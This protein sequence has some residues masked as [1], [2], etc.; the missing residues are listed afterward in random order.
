[1]FQ[2]V[3][4]KPNVV[5]PQTIYWPYVRMNKI[6]CFKNYTLEYKLCMKP[7]ERYRL[8][9]ISSLFQYIWFHI[10]ISIGILFPLS[11]QNC[12]I[13]IVYESFYTLKKTLIDTNVCTQIKH[14]W[15]RFIQ[16]SIVRSK[17]D[18]HVLIRYWYFTFRLPSSGI[19]EILLFIEVC[20]VFLPTFR[21]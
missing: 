2:C 21:L 13:D 8:R 6:C 10:N 12:Y 3:D 7:S 9:R 1:M 4:L 15:W 5:P 18:I 19:A 17:F 14:T 11:H 16:K 20:S